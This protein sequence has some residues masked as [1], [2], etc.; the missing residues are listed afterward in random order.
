VT[1]I[2]HSFTLIE[3]FRSD[4]GE[5]SVALATGT[6]GTRP[7]G[8]VDMT[9]R[10][11]LFGPIA[12][13]LPAGGARRLKWR[14][15]LAVAVVAFI[16]PSF[17]PA[18]QAD[19]Q[20]VL[21][22]AKTSGAALLR[23]SLEARLAIAYPAA[24]ASPGRARS[25]ELGTVASAFRNP[26]GPT[27]A[28][29]GNPVAVAVDNATDTVYVGNGN[30]GT[31]SVINEATCNAIHVSGC[32]Q[33]PSTIT[34]GPGPVDD[35]VD[36][37]TDT[38]YVTDL[39]TN[40]VSVIDGATC[41]AHNHSGCNQT[42]PTIKVGNNPDGVAIDEATHTVYVT[43]VSDNT[44]SVINEATCNARVTW[45][46][47]QV[48]PTVSVGVQ[49]AVP[50]VDEATDTVYVPNSNP[51]GP[52][53]I[54]VIDGATCNASVTTGCG[55]TPP[56]IAVGANTFPVAAAVDQAT[57]TIYETVYG[58]SLGSV[59][60][61]DGATCNAS[62]T[63]GCAQ[64][65]PTVK[66]GS[67]PIGVVV[68]P[69]TQSVFVLNEEDSTVSVIDGAICN[70]VQ[71]AGCSQHPPDVATG[72]NPGY[73][74][75]DLATDTVYASNQNENTLSVLDGGAC[76]L[77]HR[78][79][80]RE[81]ALTTTI[82][83]APA[84]SAVD[85][86]TDTVYVSN[87]SDN[88]LSVINGAACNAMNKSGCGRSW[89]TVATG[90]WPQAIA[91]NTRTDTIYTANVGANFSGGHTMSVIDGASCN[92]TNHS[93]CGQAPAVVD[94]GRLPFDLAINE[95]TDTI[96]V[97][98]AKDNTVSVINGAT[99][100]GTNHSGCGLTPP[101]ISVGGFPDGVAIDQ[102]T[103]TVYVA[104][105]ND[106]DVSVIDGATCNG[107]H[108]AGCSQ[109]APTTPTA[110]SGNYFAVDEAT[111]TVYVANYP[112]SISVID[113]ATCNATNH[114]G[115]GQIAPVMVT[116]G[117]PYGAA[118][119]Q[120]TDTVFVD[121]IWDSEVFVYDGSTCN[122]SDVTGCDQQ[123]VMVPT[124]GWPGQ[125]GVNQATHTVYIPDNVDGEV[126]FFG[127]DHGVAFR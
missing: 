89:P 62:V 105:G 79:G 74:D 29:G 103:D 22:H 38:V 124:G 26:M 53:S 1:A 78:F 60:V 69:V 56:R 84:G 65:P 119:D 101:T 8:R 28:V 102:K 94:V 13:N 45:G 100:N 106:N 121:S 57:D 109:V 50:A 126:S 68:D 90:V 4:A 76:T 3:R 51:G 67:D 108:H 9:R 35:A 42:P 87:R 19:A 30:D 112:N 97:V 123:P 47:R 72:F 12:W 114:S 66:V 7:C 70:A 10:P 104:N 127:F 117:A 5:G 75:V 52:G 20:G 33:T 25:A 14:H 93:G 77:T 113:G 54:S 81:A 58:P 61:I 36:Q 17:E 95:D 16:L 73:L 24:L 116:G 2:E 86:G 31:V 110:G 98:N 63:S 23:W 80:C 82:G 39:N 85:E 71:S 27:V 21:T 37:R 92:A 15:L 83:D 120:A 44:V 41:N 40:T 88:D 122:A 111:D 125:L 46:C 18:A 107:T 99:C 115:C 49:P 64:V 43:N 11:T 59:D 118:V 34:V 55:N 32:G 48:P 6:F 96:Y 91:V